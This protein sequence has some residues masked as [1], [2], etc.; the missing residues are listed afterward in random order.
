[1]PCSGLGLNLLSF[2]KTSSPAIDTEGDN[3][4]GEEGRRE[5]E[6]MPEQ[7]PEPDTSPYAFEIDLA[8]LAEM[9]QNSK[10]EKW[11]ADYI[12]GLTPT[13]RNEYTGMF[14][15]YNLIYL[16]AEGFSTYAVREDLTPTLY[17]MVNSSFVFSN[18]YVPIWAV[19]RHCPHLYRI[20]P[21]H[22][23]YH[24]SVG[25]DLGLFPAVGQP[26]K[27]SLHLIKSIPLYHSHGSHAAHDCLRIIIFAIIFGKRSGL[28]GSCCGRNI[29]FLPFRQYI[30]IFLNSL[31]R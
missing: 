7:D 28:P 10:E 23:R 29:L 14:E 15:G 30:F 22:A 9:S 26:V 31:C 1:M 20:C 25:G 19:C 2:L 17:K 13:N 8:K 21:G 12:A 3:L 16:T 24:I 5:A 4:F 6:E 27:K 11:L 18:Y